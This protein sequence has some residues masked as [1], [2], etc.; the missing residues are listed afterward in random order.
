MS[1]PCYLCGKTDGI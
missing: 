1:F